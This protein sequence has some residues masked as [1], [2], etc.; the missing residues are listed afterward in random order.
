MTTMGNRFGIQGL[1]TEAVHSIRDVS[2]GRISAVSR[3]TEVPRNPNSMKETIKSEFG[4]SCPDTEEVRKAEFAP[5]YN[6]IT[7]IGQTVSLLNYT[8]QATDKE[9]Y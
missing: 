9:E 3:P 8:S 2:D 4:S 6:Y 7:F 5:H 1:G